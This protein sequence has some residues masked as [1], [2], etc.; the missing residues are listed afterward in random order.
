MQTPSNVTI[1]GSPRDLP[2]PPCPLRPP[3]I[4]GERHI[5]LPHYKR[6]L[7]VGLMDL[8]APLPIS[9]FKHR[10][11]KYFG[12]ALAKYISKLAV[13]FSF[14]AKHLTVSTILIFWGGSFAKN[15]C[16]VGENNRQDLSQILSEWAHRVNIRY[17][18]SRGVDIVNCRSSAC[19]TQQRS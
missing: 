13:I 12:W 8:H 16:I 10:G 17:F 9:L 2:T 6:E 19:I 3:C 11:P 4:G 15:V 7:C 14:S 1:E 5:I 18:F